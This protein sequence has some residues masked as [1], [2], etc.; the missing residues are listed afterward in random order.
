MLVIVS[1]SITEGQIKVETLNHT[2]SSSSSSSTT[3]T[4]TTTR[5][6]IMEG[7]KENRIFK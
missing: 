6:Y 7:R 1:Q 2:S 4:T 5:S 3:T